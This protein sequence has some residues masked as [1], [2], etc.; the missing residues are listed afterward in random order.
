ME[1]A[2]LAYPSRS[3]LARL[4]MRVEQPRRIALRARCVLDSAKVN[5]LAHKLCTATDGSTVSNLIELSQSPL[6]HRAYY[7]IPV[8]NMT[9]TQLRVRSG[10]LRWEL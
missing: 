10:A 2:N 8:P 5:A 7:A 3:G 6:L 4:G 1:Q 9:S